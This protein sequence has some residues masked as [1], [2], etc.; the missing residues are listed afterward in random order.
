MDTLNAPVTLYAGHSPLGVIDERLFALLSDHEQAERWVI[1]P[2]PQHGENA[3]IIQTY[4]GIAGMLLPHQELRT[5]VAVRPLIAGLSYP[6]TY[7][8]DE[9]WI[10]LALTGQDA[11]G[12]EPNTTAFTLHPQ[13][14][15]PTSTSAEH[16]SKNSPCDPN[17]S[18][19]SPKEQGP[20]HSS[21]SPIHNPQIQPTSFPTATPTPDPV[22]HN[23]SC[24]A[25]SCSALVST[26]EPACAD[27]DR[28]V[29]GVADYE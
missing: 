14:A 9:V 4:D 12:L 10:A 3:V 13:S 7:P 16:A 26:S 5:Q 20:R 19:C 29:V 23:P 27:V 22:R 11:P 25:L 6:P 17:P 1:T 24:A 21:P 28:P 18:S 2:V 15:G 8:P